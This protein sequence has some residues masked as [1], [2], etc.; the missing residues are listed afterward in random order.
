MTSINLF[1]IDYLLVQT[2]QELAKGIEDMTEITA[3][4]PQNYAEPFEVFNEFNVSCGHTATRLRVH[5][6]G[7]FHR[8]EWNK[9]RERRVIERKAR[10]K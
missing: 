8:S 10:K 1:T 7:L 4:C 6:E 5:T 2:K 9:R 3:A